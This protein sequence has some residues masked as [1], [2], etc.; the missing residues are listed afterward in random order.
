[1]FWADRDDFARVRALDVRFGQLGVPDGVNPAAEEWKA[2]FESAGFTLVTLFAAFEGE[3]YA[4][5]PTVCETVG[6]VPHATRKAR[7]LR[8]LQVSNFAARLGCPAVACHIGC[9][10]EDDAAMRDLVRRICDHA[11]KHGQMF[12]LET[13]QERAE[14]LANF[15][16]AV[17]RPNLRVNFDPANMIMYGSADPIEALRLLSPW[18]VSVHMK[19]GYPPPSSDPKALGSE[20]PLG[21]GKVDVERFIAALREIGFQGQLNVERETE[22]QDERWRDIADAVQL[23]RRLA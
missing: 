5:I 16:R 10:E 23:L 11:A 7:E 20:R 2:A 12:A 18:V 4:D 19:D 15:I 17:D 22:D 21:Q 6:F 1:M 14:P 13:G 9:V 8:F 3:S